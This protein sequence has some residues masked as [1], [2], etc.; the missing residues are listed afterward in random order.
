MA[1]LRRGVEIVLGGSFEA[2]AMIVWVAVS[3]PGMRPFQ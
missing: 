1:V 2:R 3:R